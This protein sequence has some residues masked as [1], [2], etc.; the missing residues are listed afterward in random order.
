MTVPQ[1][2]NALA[3]FHSFSLSVPQFGYFLLL[4]LFGSQILFSALSYE[5]Y[6][7]SPE[8]QILWFLY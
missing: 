3:F 7:M 1:S 5:S 4:S 6:L 2:F 8:F